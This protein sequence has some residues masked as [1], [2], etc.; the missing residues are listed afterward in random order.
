MD[1][2]DM[3]MVRK[4]HN[5]VRWMATTWQWLSSTLESVS[6]FGQISITLDGF[7]GRWRR[8]IMVNLGWDFCLQLRGGGHCQGWVVGVGSKVPIY[9]IS[10]CFLFGS[11][12]KQRGKCS[13]KN[14]NPST[15]SYGLCIMVSFHFVLI[16]VLPRFYC[17]K[18]LCLLKCLYDIY[19]IFFF[20]LVAKKWNCI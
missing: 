11:Q 4:R 12:E 14:K 5:H 9:N 17:T 18:L 3:A 8:E 13:G 1:G 6:M 7:I 15:T 20:S 19:Y 16:Y 10:F 2:D